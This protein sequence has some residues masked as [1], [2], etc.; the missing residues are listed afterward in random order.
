M[1]KK[2]ILSVS[3]GT[4]N[5]ELESRSLGLLEEEYAGLL[6]SGKV[7]R[8]ITN[9]A[10]IQLANSKDGEAPVYAV[11]E[12]LARMVLDGVTHVYAQPAYLLHG[13]EYEELKDMVF[14]HKADFVEVKCG[15]P[16][17]STEE[18]LVK[19]AKA[20]MEPY[21]ELGDGQAVCFVGHG[22]HH[23]TNAIYCALDYCLKDLGYSNAH[24]ATFNAYPQIDRVIN[25]LKRDDV[26]QVC[27]APF[28]FL[29]GESA[30]EGVVGDGPSSMAW[31]LREAGFDVVPKGVCLGEQQS[32]R[33][34]YVSHLAEIME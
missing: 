32:I 10:V 11:R 14:S 31:K 8:A 15:T 1:K 21:G 2:A 19:V 17:L 13:V 4:N 6:P 12:T 25:H 22:S 30:M 29:A 16:L 7:Y 18:D 34:I 20:L 27:I 9:D 23:H 26:K 33:D 24:I 28:M 3:F 5:K